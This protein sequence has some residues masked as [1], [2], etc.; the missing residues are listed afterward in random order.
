MK[1]NKTNP[2]G[3]TLIELLVVISIIALLVSILMPA[4]A[5]ARMSAT[6][7]VCLSNTRQ[8]STGWFMYQDD[9]N[10][11]IMSALENGTEGWVGSPRYENGG[12]PSITQTSPVVTDEDEIR[13][14]KL[15]VLYPYLNDPG[16]YNCPGD[17][18]RRSKYDM[19]R[20]FVSYAI[21]A[22]LN[23][24]A[25]SFEIK[26]FSKIKSPSGKYVFVETAETRNWNMGSRF[27]IAA[28]EYTGNPAFGWWGP[29]AINHGNKSNL[30]FADGHSESRSWQDQFTIDRVN[31][32]LVQQVEWYNKEWPPADQQDDIGFMA[33]GWAYR[34]RVN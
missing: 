4:L 6:S 2:K 34:H 7:V 11:R 25:S 18:K 5:K 3:F 32:L 21:P 22:C 27:I 28:P 29:M 24:K 19:S 26:K 20:V 31:K 10:G 30:G 33:R 1:T 13:G 16:V 15:G 17:T 23:G 14:I 12:N 9:N 8:L